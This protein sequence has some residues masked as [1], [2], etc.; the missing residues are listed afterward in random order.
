MDRGDVSCSLLEGTAWN[1]KGSLGSTAKREMQSL[2]LIINCGDPPGKAG[3][4]SEYKTKAYQTSLTC[5]H[6]N[7]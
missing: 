6:P 5:T 4:A 1:V 2:L 7:S 3:G